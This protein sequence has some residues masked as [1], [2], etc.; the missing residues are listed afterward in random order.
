MKNQKTVLITGATSGYGLET[1]KLFRQNGY[2]VLIASRNPQKV[3]DCTAQYGFAKGYTLDVTDYDGWLRLRDD[4]TRDFGRLDVLVNNA[5]A[6]IAIV[7]T[8]AQ[9]K[10]TI[11]RIVALNLTANIYGANVLAPMMTAQRDGVIINVSSIC[12]RHQW[13]GWTVYGCAKAGLLSFSKGLYTELRPHGVRVCCVMPGQASTGFQHGS[14]IGEVTESL[15]AED[16]ANAV[17]YCAS[18][19]KEVV[20][21]EVTV[22]GTSQDVQPL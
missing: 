22:W 15:R 9:T 8:T 7:P 14:G 13:P 2:T 12:A 10:D 4:L 11:D 16:I 1:A 17:W 21:E 3:A 5:G 19:P 6:G 18:Q 20:I